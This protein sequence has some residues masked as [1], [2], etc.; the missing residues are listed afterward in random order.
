MNMD[1][2]GELERGRAFYVR[3]AWADAYQSLST[4]DHAGGLGGDDLELLA[5]SAY[6]TGRDDEY[7]AALGRTHDAYVECGESLR[8]A[9]CAFWLGLRLMFRGEMGRASGWLAR[10]QRLVEGEDDGCAERGYLLLPIVEQHLA[11]G[12]SEAA[13][14][15]AT[16]AAE[17][18]ERCGQGDLIACAR[19]L[20]GRVR[21]QQ[22]N[23]AEGFTLLDEAMVGVAS[24][25]LSP[26]MT[27]LIYCSVI[28]A[29][30]E[31]YAWHRAHEW[32]AAL[33]RWCAEQ[34]QLVAF[35]GVCS[36]HRAEILQLQG[37]WQESIEEARRACERCAQVAN[38]Q[39]VAAAFYQEAEVHRLR[40]DFS[41]AEAAYRSSS[42]WGRDPQPGLALLRLVQGR[43]DTAAA[44]IRRAMGTPGARLQ[45]TTLL[46][47]CVEIMIAIGEIEEARNACLELEQIAERLD[48]GVLGAIA[49]Q[50]RGAIALADG[51]PRAA[52]TSL[53]RAWQTWQ[54]AEAPYM[55]ARVRLLAGL[56]C[57][58]LGDEDGASLELEAARAVLEQ[59]GAAPDLA[60][61]AV[62]CHSASAVHTHGLT[63]R[64]LQVLRLIATGDTN[65]AIAARLFL[66]EKTVD[67]HV[68]NIFNK[69]N[70]PSRA[71]ATA[72][73]YEHK[74]I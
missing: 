29:C 31:V 1:T 12:D 54:E 71:A 52:L 56:A 50:A 69:L 47:A 48:A 72:F 7:L 49:A 65:K 22:G 63:A 59:L 9:R 62:L 14:A 38:R 33:A 11:A 20:Q 24:G 8:A 42:Q 36:V 30:Q 3:R 28:E 70:V 5:M 57:R 26:L 18:G 74:L 17:I 73:A 39:S 4:A 66:S 55:G 16:R 23:V 68:S 25:E 53:R 21:I 64:E 10:A 43:A 6:L 51:D 41:A 60:R 19:H 35:T 2:L 27:G 58:A 40:G 67:R 44:T 32:T 45:R 34:G 37:A 46:S 15:T 61:M 13:Y